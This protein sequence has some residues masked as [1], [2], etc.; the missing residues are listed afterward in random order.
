[1]GNNDV[2]NLEDNGYQTLMDGIRNDIASLS[3]EERRDLL[4]SVFSCI[5]NTTLNGSDTPASVG[6]FCRATAKMS[7]SAAYGPISVASVCVYPCFVGLAKQILGST[8][9][10]V[11]SVA[12][13][14]PAGQTSQRVKLDEVRYVIDEGAD[15]VDFVINRGLFLSGDTK[16]VFDEI[17]AA[18]TLCGSAHLKVIIECGD[19]QTVSNVYSAS[20]LALE[21]GA[22]FIKTSTGKISVGATPEYAFAMLSALNVNAKN[23]KKNCGFKAAGGVSTPDDALLYL[24]MYKKIFDAENISNQTFR[25]GTS[26]LTNQLLDIL[27]F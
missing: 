21:A 23:S 22:D 20:L 12:G 18:K 3:R 14:F 2:F 7:V 13:G 27:T 11:A 10:K 26:R 9:I 16:S 6:D 19:L 5:D 17:A 1:M 25:I 24:M 15:E 8:D 4:C